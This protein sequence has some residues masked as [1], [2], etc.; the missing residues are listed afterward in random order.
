MNQTYPDIE[1]ICIDDCSTDGSREILENL[2]NCDSRIILIRHEKNQGAYMAR[3]TGLIYATGDY[4]LFLDSDDTLKPYACKLLSRFIQKTRS[5]IIQFGYEEIPG[6]RK[7]FPEFYRS[8][9][10]RI[11]RYLADSNRLSP[12]LWTKAYSLTVIKQACKVMAPFYTVFAEDLYVSIVMAYFAK[13]FSFLRKVLVCYS[14]DTGISKRQEHSSKTY[15][16]WLLS[17][18]AVISNIS[19]FI[20]NN[21]SEYSI[22]LQNMELHLLK[23]F[24]FCRIPGNL[25]VKLKYQIFSLIPAYF[26]E[27]TFCLFYNEAAYK[28]TMYNLYLDMEC[29]FHVK[30]KKLLKNILRYFRSLFI[31]N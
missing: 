6:R 5:D 9:R 10:E 24:L 21:I 30:T 11:Q 3:Y 2:K 15:Q 29:S 28:F 16:V 4:V 13:T 22:L 31:H 7:V 17:Y 27:N 23:D 14:S 19:T 12:E 8:S 25:P 26:S 20:T 18:Q 1:I